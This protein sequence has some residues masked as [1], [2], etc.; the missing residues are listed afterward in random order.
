[1]TS[2]IQIHHT[3]WIFYTFDSAAWFQWMFKFTIFV[4][5]LTNSQS[6]V[7]KIKLCDYT[8]CITLCIQ[9]VC[10]QNKCNQRRKRK[11]TKST[12]ATRD[13][14]D[15]H[16]CQLSNAAK[17]KKNTRR[18]IKIYAKTYTLAYHSKHVQDRQQ[19]TVHCR[20]M[21]IW[22]NRKLRLFFDSHKTISVIAN[23]DRN[24]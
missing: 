14:C 22:S 9:I 20:L 19:T 13:H 24:K 21:W 8:L 4:W 2:I 7:S 23:F 1:M 17:E 6:F 18:A 11:S 5:K 10:K 12:S 16:C 3:N 15:F